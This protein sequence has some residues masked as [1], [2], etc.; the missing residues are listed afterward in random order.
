MNSNLVVLTIVASAAL[1]CGDDEGD[2]SALEVLTIEVSGK[3]PDPV[4]FRWE[5]QATFLRVLGCEA[6]QGCVKLECRANNLLYENASTRWSLGDSSDYDSAI[7]PPITYGVYQ[8]IPDPNAVPMTQ[9][10]L[11]GVEVVRD[12]A[13]DPPEAGCSKTVAQGCA[14]FTP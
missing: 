12:T 9:G 6:V 13:C 11:H 7:L 14:L 1:G 5:G 4:E 10:D 2:G 8:G 3:L